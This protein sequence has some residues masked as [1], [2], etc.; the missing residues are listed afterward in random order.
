MSTEARLD[1][2]GLSHLADKPEELER[3]LREGRER[4]RKQAESGEAKRKARLAQMQKEGK[5]P[6][7]SPSQTSTD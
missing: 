7:S 3:E 5:M 4:L 2:L 6:A 1:R